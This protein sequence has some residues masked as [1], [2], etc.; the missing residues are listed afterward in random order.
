MDRAAVTLGAIGRRQ[1]IARAGCAEIGALGLIGTGDRLGLI[2]IRPA[3]AAQAVREIR[4]EARQVKWELALHGA[5][6]EV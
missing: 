4:L 6:E 1:F 5:E 2:A 3:G